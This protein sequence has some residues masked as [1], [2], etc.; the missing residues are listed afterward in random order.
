MAAESVGLSMSCIKAIVAP[1]PTPAH[2]RQIPGFS[3]SGSPTGS[4]YHDDNSCER[5][6]GTDSPRKQTPAASV[7][8]SA[9]GSYGN[10][11]SAPRR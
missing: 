9:F 8:S 7:Q 2:V 1:S 3:L 4:L 5:D 10:R 6:T 11:T